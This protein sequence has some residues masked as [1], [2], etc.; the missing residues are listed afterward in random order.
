V[1]KRIAL[2]LA[3]AVGL[4]GGLGVG[5]EPPGK[6]D[7]HSKLTVV[8]TSAHCDWTWGHSRA[9]H[10]ERYAQILHDV[11]LLMRQYPGYVWQLENENE[12]LA[13]FLKKAAKQ[14][15]GMIDEFWQRVREGRI[16]VIV[17]ISDPRLTEV[18]PE[19]IV[20]NMVLGKEYF[21][22]HAPGI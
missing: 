3:V 11:L 16:E 1:A 18:Y 6:R 22:R 14:W 19:T 5:A 8:T 13:P 17:A 20:R 2:G 10:E 9:W 12:E 4:L 15:P 7:D 21:R